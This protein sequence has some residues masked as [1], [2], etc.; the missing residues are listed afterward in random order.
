MQMLHIRLRVESVAALKRR[1]AAARID[2][3]DY[4]ELVLW[5]AALDFITEEHLEAG[6]TGMDDEELF[7][8]APSSP[9]LRARMAARSAEQAR[10]LAAY[11]GSLVERFLGKFE[12]D[13][14]DLRMLARLS[15][16]LEQGRM[17]TDR[18]LLDVLRLAEGTPVSRMPSAFQVRWLHQRLRPF[19]PRITWEGAPVELTVER[20]AVLRERAKGSWE[21]ES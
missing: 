15:E 18:E 16:L 4:V 10:N 5:Y 11:T 3:A 13:P 7:F 21:E 20:L 1:A 6:S 14:G 8:S 19:L 2:A 12:R 17:L 9:A